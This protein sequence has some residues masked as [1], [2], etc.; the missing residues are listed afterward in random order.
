[1][2]WAL[3]PYLYH[4]V[5]DPNILNIKS[6]THTD[7]QTEDLLS[8]FLSFPFSL[9][10]SDTHTPVLSDSV[11]EDGVIYIVVILVWGHYT[12]KHRQPIISNHHSNVANTDN[13]SFHIT[14]AT[15]Q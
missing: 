12:C 10:L 9:S 2:Q 7:I 15:L 5:F 14:I 11:C 3:N 13:P 8:L 6:K 4:C 1:Q